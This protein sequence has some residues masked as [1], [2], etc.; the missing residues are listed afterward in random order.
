MTKAIPDL[1]AALAAG[2]TSSRVLVESCLDRI[3]AENEKL[4]AYLSVDGDA[5]RIVADS[6]DAMRK[7]GMALSPL[8][9]IPVSVKDLFDVQGQVTT[10]GSVVL[11]DDAPATGDAPAI[12]RL[13]AAGMI[14]IGRTNMSEFAFSGVGLNPHYGTPWNPADRDAHRIPGGSS[15]GAAV[16]VAADMAAVGIGTDT[17]G[18]CRIPAAY[19]GIVGYKPTQA[20]VP[21]EKVFPLARSLDSVGP[22][23][24]TV[25]CCAII[26]AL[27][28]GMPA[29]DGTKRNPKHIRLAV[30]Q[31]V[32]LDDLDAG[33]V[34][35]FSRALEI[36]SGAGIAIEEIPFKE[37]AE[38]SWINAR[39]GMPSAEAFA[40]HRSRLVE[41][42]HLYDRRVAARIGLGE[43]ALAADYIQF[44]DERAEL[45]EAAAR[46][47]CSYDAV[48]L[49][50]TPIVAPPVADLESDDGYLHYN[51]LSLRNTLIGNFLN[52]C[53]IS[54]P[55]HKQGD[56]PVGLMLMGATG[57][58]EALFGVARTVEAA[59]K[60][61]K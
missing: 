57:G 61:A 44:L 39:G 5:A 38:I 25:D 27:M 59:L 20:R 31:T 45:I 14:L 22:L 15:S 53:A 49:P 13:R 10:A 33:V 43:G 50:T 32:V 52:R 16:S 58:D 18:S 30:P 2:R 1:I 42:K 34:S 26:D 23:A 28:A 4:A 19:C 37:L 48:V 29:P 6:I 56:P 24:N 47:T 17:G 7:A 21:R 3:D 41:M 9:G 12:G 46:V 60:D 54:L 35:A 8:A 11:K 51:G 36:L 55:C 40:V